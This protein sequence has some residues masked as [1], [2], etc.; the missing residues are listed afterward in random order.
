MDRKTAL[1]LAAQAWCTKET[2]GMILIPELAEAFADI[3]L[4]ELSRLNTQLAEAR[5]A[6]ETAEGQVDR[7]KD[8]VKTAEAEV[9]RLREAL[10]KIAA[11]DS[12]EIGSTKLSDC[13][14]AYAQAALKAE[15]EG[16]TD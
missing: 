2:S 4:S 1:G 10:Q 3:L 8:A 14:A 6:H 9:E 11:Q 5:V 16:C 12:G 13:M 15:G 7:W